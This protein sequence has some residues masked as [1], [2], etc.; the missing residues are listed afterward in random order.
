MPPSHQFEYLPLVLRESGLARFPQVPREEDPTTVI[1]RSDRG[2][3]SAGLAS[4]TTTASDNWKKKQEAREADGL[5]TVE[6]GIPLV[7]KIDPSLELDDLRRQFEFEIVSE[8]EDGFVIVASEDVD[9]TEFQRKLTDYVSAVTGSG[10]IAKIHELKEDLTQEERLRLILTE[11]A[12]E[13]WPNLVDDQEYIY[14]LSITCVGS[15]EVPK[16]PKRN[17]R[18]K[19][20]TW[21]R[22][23]NEWSQERLDVYEKW[24]QLKDS[25]LTTL[26]SI[27]EHYEGKHRQRRC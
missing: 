15:W 19:P 25:R 2:T 13:Q 26:T 24:D 21:A 27:I 10:N 16:K 5:P 22:K 20:E 1:N 12:M 11:A 14:D 18:W 9:L 7:L 3:H 8:Q 6:G 17:P 4:A 23:E